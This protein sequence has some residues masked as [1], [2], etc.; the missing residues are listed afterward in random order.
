MLKK[1]G[2]SLLCWNYFIALEADLLNISSYIEFVEA[3]R[4][5]CPSSATVE[6]SNL[7]KNTM[8]EIDAVAF[9]S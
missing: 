2:L 1:E 8:M 9:S 6:A 4:E 5:R 7:P 3:N